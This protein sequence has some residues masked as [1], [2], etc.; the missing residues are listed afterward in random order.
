MKKGK[1]ILPVLF[2]FMVAGTYLLLNPPIDT[3]RLLLFRKFI[4]DPQSYLEWQM[5][6]GERCGNAPFIFPSQGFVGFLWGDR[7]RPGH[8]HQG[9]DIFGGTKAGQTPV[10]AVHDG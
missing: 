6:A 10:L 5:K 9:I 7:F 8:L 1:L 3:G 4:R 2:V